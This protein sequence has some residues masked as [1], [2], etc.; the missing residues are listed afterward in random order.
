MTQNVT[1][2]YIPQN[3]HIKEGKIYTLYLNKITNLDLNSVITSRSSNK[4]ND[5]MQISQ[6]DFNKIMVLLDTSAKL[7]MQSQELATKIGKGRM[8]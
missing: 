7:Y 2:Y 3:L 6:D 8:K 4:S 1:T 5:L